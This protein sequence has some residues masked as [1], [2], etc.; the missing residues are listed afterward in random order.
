M[1]ASE[2]LQPSLYVS[3]LGNGPFGQVH[4]QSVHGIPQ[5]STLI[6]NQVEPSSRGGAGVALG[7]E[8]TPAAN[9]WPVNT[10]GPQQLLAAQSSDQ[11]EQILANFYMSNA[12][13]LQMPS[14]SDSYAPINAASYPLQSPQNL[15]SLEPQQQVVQPS[16]AAYQH[17]FAGHND[18]T[19]YQQQLALPAPQM[20]DESALGG[21]Q[22]VNRHRATKQAEKVSNE[23]LMSLIEELKDYNKRKASEIQASST[24]LPPGQHRV[25]P[26]AKIN[27]AHV[28]VSSPTSEELS[29]KEDQQQQDSRFQVNDDNEHRPAEKLDATSD[30][31]R[32]DADD[33]AKF[34][35]FLM[36][37]EGANMKFQLGLEKDSPDDGDEE[38]DR[39]ALLDAARTGK[40]AAAA[41]RGR[42]QD[43]LDKR[44][45]DVVNQM[46]RMLDGLNDRTKELGKRSK[47]GKKYKT[48][49]DEDD[50]RDVGRR[51][52]SDGG[53]SKRAA[54]TTERSGPNHRQPDGL[55][56]PER[57]PLDNLGTEN[58]AKM[59]IK[60]ELMEDAREDSAGQERPASVSDDR[61]AAEPQQQRRKIRSYHGEHLG[62]VSPSPQVSQQHI[63]GADERGRFGYPKS[64]RNKDQREL[65]NELH[66]A[67]LKK[68]RTR[69]RIPL[70]VNSV[71]KRA[72]DGELG[73]QAERRPNN[74]LVLR[75]TGQGDAAAAALTLRLP[76][77]S[78]KPSTSV[79]RQTIS[80][81]DEPAT[82]SE[83]IPLS[84]EPST[85]NSKPQ[86]SAGVDAVEQVKLTSK[87]LADEYPISERVSDR[88]NKLSNNL[89][90]YF[91]DGFIQEIE[92]KA[93]LNSG[94]RRRRLQ[95]HHEASSSSNVNQRR[96]DGP[97]PPPRGDHDFDV[98]VGIDG[99]RDVDSSGQ[100]ESGDE[101]ADGDNRE[102]GAQRAVIGSD[103]R[104]T[105]RAR[106]T[107][108][109]PL[110][111]V[112]A[113]GQ[114][115][116]RRRQSSAP[117]KTTTTTK[118]NRGAAKRGKQTQDKAMTSGI[119]G[120]GSVESGSLRRDVFGRKENVEFENTQN[121]PVP[122][123]DPVENETLETPIGPDGDNSAEPDLTKTSDKRKVASEQRNVS[124]RYGKKGEAAG[125]FY[126][127]PDWKSRRRRR[128]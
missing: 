89:D 61:V 121:R 5:K 23:Q 17:Q 113:G 91:N 80:S 109:R 10:R 3:Y 81:D 26:T 99:K 27:K 86:L 29:E 114:Q 44:Q 126:E 77:H 45:S 127:E 68:S 73:L 8:E 115:Q 14:S 46:D 92:T 15:A 42:Q 85:A 70:A 52:R 94:R 31:S 7:K 71:L 64:E 19:V 82:N 28:D 25:G 57:A 11:Q 63:G 2:G 74:H 30:G 103:S 124:V 54:A 117:A 39:D 111:K 75:T 112:P 50:D 6:E 76:A 16:A 35:K 93:H 13:Y 41:T 59:L 102:L 53:D 108:N 37:K 65:L 4:Q 56:N 122:S 67:R 33:L 105:G 95:D 51:R 98:D 20:S 40:S 66:K 43:E 58:F 79:Q 96:N 120:D 62:S 78:S 90:K 128:R 110:T 48:T 36:T 34:A 116:S 9:Y 21:R 123:L 118:S 47:L 22:D 12:H 125:K 60:R 107:S 100:D 104:K 24:V 83:L 97:P 84:V 87:P 18:P 49:D 32:F 69:E 72:L 55:R 106:R 119:V 88:L 1:G 38:D 101:E